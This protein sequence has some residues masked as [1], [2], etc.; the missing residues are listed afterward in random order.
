[1]SIDSASLFAGLFLDFFSVSIGPLWGLFS[2]YIC[3]SVIHISIDF[4][5]LFAGLSLQVSFVKEPYKKRLY[6]AKETYNFKEP[7]NRRH[8]IYTCQSTLRVSLRVFFWI[9]FQYL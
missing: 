9:S 3:L 2:G 4:V 1:M 6:S 7:T 8:P 5:S